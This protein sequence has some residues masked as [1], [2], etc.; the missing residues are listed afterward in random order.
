M[1]L[2][3]PE[4]LTFYY[5]LYACLKVKNISLQDSRPHRGLH[6]DFSFFVFLE[7][8]FVELKGVSL[9]SLHKETIMPSCP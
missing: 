3:S 8:I 2:C 9:N 7:E 4:V 1:A 6:M 5:L